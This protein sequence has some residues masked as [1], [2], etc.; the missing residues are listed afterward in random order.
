MISLPHGSKHLTSSSEQSF[1]HL[2][3]DSSSS[4]YKLIFTLVDKP[5]NAGSDWPS[6]AISDYK[7]V[8]HK[9][10]NVDGK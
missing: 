1:S 6:K 7:I 5:A 9:N 4:Q 8:K 2:F 10:V 3:A